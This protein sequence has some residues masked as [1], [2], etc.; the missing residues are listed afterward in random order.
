M[1]KDKYFQAIPKTAISLSSGSVS[2][3]AAFVSTPGFCLVSADY[4]QIEL[5]ILAHLSGD[6]SL[7]RN[8]TNYSLDKFF[9]VFQYYF[10][11]IDDDFL[12]LLLF[13]ITIYVVCNEATQ[14]HKYKTLYVIDD[15]IKLL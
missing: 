15:G 9:L 7:L 14:I 13:F 5:R 12:L 3:R 4:E 6:P 11:I 10:N 8:W 2:L 1:D